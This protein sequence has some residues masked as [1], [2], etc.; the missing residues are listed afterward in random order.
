ML[1]VSNLPRAL[2]ERAARHAEGRRAR[3]PRC[4]VSWLADGSAI[5]VTQADNCNAGSGSIVRV[6]PSDSATQTQLRA[7]GGQNPWWKY[8]TPP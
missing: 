7:S 6:S 2:V 4:E 5:V 1:V 8:L 3:D